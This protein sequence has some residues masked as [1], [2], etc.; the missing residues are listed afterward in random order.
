MGIMQDKRLYGNII[1][2]EIVRASER[3]YRRFANRFKFDPERSP[4]LACYSE[5][6]GNRDFGI[7]TVREADSSRPGAAGFDAEKGVVLGTIRM[8][9]GHCRMAISLASAAH[10]MG[11]TPYWLDLMSFPDYAASK[12]IKYLEGLYNLGSRL[13]QRSKLFDSLI[14]DYVTNGAARK[15][16]FSV[17]EDALSRL[18]VPL[19]KDIPKDIPFFSTH[20]WTGHA[21]CGAGMTDVI[22]I[23]PDNF[24]LAFHVV[25]GSHHVVQSP[26]S[27]M[28]YRTFHSMGT[29]LHLDHT[30]PAD[31]IT[32]VGHYVDHEIVSNVEEDC[33][34]RLKR[35]KDGGTRRFLLTMG[36]AG[37]QVLR[38]ADIAK[39]CKAA[40]ED[41][42]V[43]LL[44]NMGDHKG[45]WAELEER[46]RADGISWTLHSDWDETRA[47]IEE[48]S[49]SR[50]S[51]VHVFLHDDFYCA[52]YAT[53]LLMRVC[54]VMVTKP[55]ELSFYP[56]PK[57]FIQR[58]GRHEA[59]GAIRGA[60]IGDGTIETASV[61]GL[62]RILRMLVED[63]DL[64]ALYC[65][66]I[67]RNKR[68][69][70]YD[71][72]YNAVKVAMERKKG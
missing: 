3:R 7:M 55:S 45:R 37:A 14:W 57:L 34:K 33:D 60:E 21:A 4:S 48:A 63:E 46:F 67:V 44:V 42:K 11:Y 23:I 6:F 51:G 39:T 71:G 68:D 38:F 28:G 43:S 9:F 36:G 10:S 29:G 58:V 64:L 65:A 12:T 16:S 22:T 30:M 66:H 41:K 19:Y 1:P 27:Y 50:I 25:E 35:I 59:W 54:D 17:E 26:S 62:H 70:I 40:I 52:V 20:P 56:V 15:L 8:G 69:G 13:S 47:F 18:F 32:M 31:D 5:G 24:P 72:A 53:N 49:V 2:R 61:T